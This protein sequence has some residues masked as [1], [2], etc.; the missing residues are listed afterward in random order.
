MRWNFFTAVLAV[1]ITAGSIAIEMQKANAQATA[2]SSNQ[3]ARSVLAGAPTHSAENFPA[4]EGAGTKPFVFGRETYKPNNENQTCGF[5]KLQLPERIKI[6]AIQ[7]AGLKQNFQIDQSGEM[8][9]RVDVVVNE[10][11]T[12][13]VLMLG[14]YEPSVWNIGWTRGTKILAVIAGGYGKQVLNGLPQDVP[15][16]AGSTTERGTC[17]QFFSSLER[18]EAL[19]PASRQIFG[20][21]VDMLYQ[22]ND[23]KA[24][25]GQLLASNA[26][27]VTADSAKPVESFGIPESQW[28]GPPA[29]ELAV[30]HGYLRVAGQ[31]DVDAWLA[32]QS[33]DPA[34]ADIPPLAKGAA[35]LKPRLIT[36][37]GYCSARGLCFAAGIVWFECSHLFCAEG[38]A[39]AHW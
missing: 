3:D 18:A 20:H 35:R 7:G 4:S 37:R 24:I 33:V 36:T 22:V 23:G 27:L 34:Q 14:N 30:R 12:P 29:L 16:R 6:F 31:A 1:L 28:A 8:A 5:S 15:T 19:N 2:G 9:T 38:C 13:V 25:V 39:T 11:S 26:M 32:A 21:E 17:A 10:P